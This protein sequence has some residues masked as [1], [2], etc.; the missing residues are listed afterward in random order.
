MLVER[1]RHA[2]LQLLDRRQEFPA[3]GGD[4]LL[5]ARAQA[6]HELEA[7]RGVVAAGGPVPG[8][9]DGR[10]RERLT[11]ELGDPLGLDD[12]VDA[13]ALGGEILIDERQVRPPR[14]PYS[15]SD[16]RR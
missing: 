6:G 9:R 4:A 12:L 11:D 15:L 14:F 2:A 16:F 13:G 8:L 10:L 5:H 7:Q 1:L 3:L